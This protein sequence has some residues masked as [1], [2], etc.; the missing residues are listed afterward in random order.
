VVCPSYGR[1]ITPLHTVLP[2]QC[3]IVVCPVESPPSMEMC[4]RCFFFCCLLGAHPWSSTNLLHP[5]RYRSPLSLLRSFCR[6]RWVLGMHQAVRGSQVLAA[7]GARWW[8]RQHDSLEGRRG[9][10]RVPPKAAE[11]CRRVPTLGS[12]EVSPATVGTHQRHCW[13]EGPQPSSAAARRSSQLST[14]ARLRRSE[15][16]QVRRW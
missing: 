10:A 3:Q 5:W 15:L 9:R 8:R 16:Q 13:L 11:D 6:V 1:I 7:R 4:C 2:S 14:L 12:A